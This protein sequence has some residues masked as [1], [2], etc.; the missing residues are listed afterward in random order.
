MA[1]EK[2][3]GVAAVMLVVM[4]TQTEAA[5][6]VNSTDCG[7]NANCA[8]STC[9]CDP[10]YQGDGTTCTTMCSMLDFLLGVGFLALPGDC[11]RF[12]QCDVTIPQ[13]QYCGYGTVW[14]DV[15]KACVTPSDGNCT[16]C[17]G[18]ADGVELPYPLMCNSYWQCQ[19][20]VPRAMCCPVNNTFVDGSGCVSGSCADTC[21]PA[22]ANYT[23]D[24]C[25]LTP[26]SD[27]SEF[28][29]ETVPGFGLIR[30]DCPSGTNFNNA[31][32]GC[33]DVVSVPSPPLC[34]RMAD[35][36][37]DNA[38]TAFVD[39]S[40]N[41]AWIQVNNVALGN[42]PVFSGSSS[43]TVF[44]LAGVTYGSNLEIDTVFS[45]NPSSPINNQIVLQNGKCDDNGA[46]FMLY[47]N[48]V[49]GN[50]SI[51]DVTFTLQTGNS[52]VE[53]NSTLTVDKTTTVRVEVKYP[54]RSNSST[55]SF[56][57]FDDDTDM[58]VTSATDAMPITTTITRKNAELQI[59]S[60]D[61]TSQGFSGFVG[62]IFKAGIRSCGYG[63]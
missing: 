17:S 63:I 11:S 7:V 16:K 24:P 12:V 5:A 43:L 55:Y 25:E 52:V 61:C 3:C 38:T 57:L 6:C 59:G 53:I 31:T 33:H 47:V 1:M 10:G 50:A 4:I 13:V 30:R 40:T 42:K 19:G 15:I 28:Y 14:S 27:G 23:A 56:T 9:V 18:Q 21:P 34:P 48:E 45:V 62:S 26:S 32:C 29:M 49:P 36:Y 37:Y 22:L 35:I 46:S 44:A 60:G 39:N 51:M 20:G 2:M 41:D 54:T 58:S 8:N